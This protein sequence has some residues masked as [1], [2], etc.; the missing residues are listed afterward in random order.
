MLKSRSNHL[1]RAVAVAI[2]VAMKNAA[3]LALRRL[4]ATTACRL[5]DRSPGTRGGGAQQK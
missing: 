1:T 2:V 3:P 4:P 5:V